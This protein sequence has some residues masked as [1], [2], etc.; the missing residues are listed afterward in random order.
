MEVAV[1]IILVLLQFKH[2]YIDFVAQSSDMVAGKGVYGN[3]YGLLH[4]VQHG[5]G[6]LVVCLFFVQPLLAIGLGILDFI[7]HY[8]IDYAKMNLGCQDVKEKEFWVHL[9]LDQMLH[10]ITYLIIALLVV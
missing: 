9:G 6:T 7:L 10:Q 1:I 8:H 3:L 4:S 2:W 5:F